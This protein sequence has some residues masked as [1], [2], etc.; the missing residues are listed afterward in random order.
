M[1]VDQQKWLSGVCQSTPYRKILKVVKKSV[2]K[3]STYGAASYLKLV[4]GVMT[5][6]PD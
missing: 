6:M 1:H 5:V 2:P 4:H 3:I